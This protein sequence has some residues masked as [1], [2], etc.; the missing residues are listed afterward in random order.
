MKKNKHVKVRHQIIHSCLK[1]IV[2]GIVSSLFHIKM[3]SKYKIAKGEKVFVVSN[4]Q[5]DVDP[6]F[7]TRMF[8]KPIYYVAT[9][10]LATS[11]AYPIIDF[12]LHPIMKKKGESDFACIKKMYEVNEEGGSIGLFPEG[13]RPYAE[14]QFPI[15]KVTAKLIK[16]LKSTLVI[17][18]INGGTGVSPRFGFKR[19]R[20]PGSVSIKRVLK[21]EEYSQMDDEVLCQLI[22]DDL[23]VFDSE[24]G[25]LYKSNKRAE[26]LEREFFLCPSCKAVSSMVSSKNIVTCA[27]CGT[28]AEFTEG[29]HFKPLREDFPFTKMLEWYDYQKKWIAESSFESEEAIFVDEN[30]RLY[31]LGAKK[32][33]LLSKG[34][35]VLTKDSIQFEGDVRLPLSELSVSSPVSGRKLAMTVENKSYMV[36]GHQ[37]FNPLKY[38]L[39][40]NKLETK[41]KQTHNDIY[42]RID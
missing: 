25:N 38:S 1:G 2:C 37:R 16:R 40:F 28:K 5:T 34:K 29:L 8:N 14:F 11:A 24:S 36:V 22:R 39:I 3:R 42:F 19:R 41:M 10:T 12:V 20:G 23:K 18:N 33:K 9:D 35:M 21:Y 15:E 7:I 26:Y 32:R 27:K 4:H 31:E 17:V 13:N 30:V 6:F